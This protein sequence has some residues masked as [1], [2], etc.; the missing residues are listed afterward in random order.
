[1]Q[2]VYTDM[3]KEGAKSMAQTEAQKR[4]KELYDKR[5]AKKILLKLNINTDADIL[6]ILEKSGNKQGYI[7][8]LIRADKG[9][10]IAKGANV[11]NENNG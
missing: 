1:M 11:E 8:A 2:S 10:S 6:E 4:A 5:T 9:K 3:R 7:K